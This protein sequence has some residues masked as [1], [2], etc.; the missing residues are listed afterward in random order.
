MTVAATV[1]RAAAITPIR[2]LIADLPRTR[3]EMGDVGRPDADITRRFVNSK[4]VG[5]LP[6]PAPRAGARGSV[7][8][9]PPHATRAPPR[10]LPLSSAECRTTA[11]RSAP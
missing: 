9:A 7:G 8:V 6:F 2:S 11:L 10:S 4:D 3:V 1:A 5:R